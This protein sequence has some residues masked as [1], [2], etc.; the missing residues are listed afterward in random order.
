MGEDKLSFDILSGCGT[1][2]SAFSDEGDEQKHFQLRKQ[3]LYQ[4]VKENGFLE[5]EHL[6]V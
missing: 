6:K 2:P 3:N 1:F 5:S 4:S